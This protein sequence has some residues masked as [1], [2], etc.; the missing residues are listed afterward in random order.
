MILRDWR[1]ADPAVVRDCYE[2]ERAHWRD[3]LGWDT[4]WTWATVE[5]AR[6]ANGLPGVLALNRFDRVRGWAFY[7]V[8]RATLHVGGLV[9]ED[10]ETTAAIV[11]MMLQAGDEARVRADACFILDRADGLAAV[12]A[13]RGFDL[14]TF[15][16]L[17]LDLAALGGDDGGLMTSE[18]SD[19]DVPAAAALLETSYTPAAGIHF[20]PTGDWVKYVAGLVSQ[21]G[22]GT[23]DPRLSHVVRGRSRLDALVM[24]TSL[25]AD[26][27]HIAQVA[28]HPDQR[29]RGIASRLVRRS[30]ADAAR[31]GK[32]TLT[33]LVGDRNTPA[34]TLY[35]S[36]GFTPRATF[37]AA[38]RER[39]AASRQA[40]RA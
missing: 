16:Y 22:C 28:V 20:A 8:D 27:A 29:G 4:A 19:A 39:T 10:A 40:R 26:T 2:R 30:A 14:E 25:S 35:A 33:L 32:S 15:H 11:D 6:V 38:R 24:G 9:A 13:R 17:T 23:F 3:A 1:G 7:V 5:Q 36:L 34:R 18:W 21:A 31:A 37:L 12:L